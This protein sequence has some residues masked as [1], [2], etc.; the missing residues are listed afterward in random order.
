MSASTAISYHLAIL[1]SYVK[2]SRTPQ[3]TGISRG[4]RS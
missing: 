3:R 4:D 1:D 2:H